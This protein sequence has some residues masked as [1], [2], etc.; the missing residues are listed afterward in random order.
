MNIV[1]ESTSGWGAMKEDNI[2]HIIGRVIQR[3]VHKIVFKMLR[4]TVEKRV[5][6]RLNFV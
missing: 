2:K 4:M 3:S 6:S 5:R 1:M